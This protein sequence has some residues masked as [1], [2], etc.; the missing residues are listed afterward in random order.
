MKRKRG[1]TIVELMMVIAVIAI[2]AGII[3]MGV[4]G[5]FRSARAK[6]AEAMA[7][8]LQSGL[9]TYYAQYGKWPASIKSHENDDED[10]VELDN[11]SGKA[12]SAHGRSPETDSAFQ[13]IVKRSILSNGKPVLDPSGLFVAES[14]NEYC[15]DNHHHQ[16][17]SQAYGFCTRK[18][19]L[20]GRD[21][22]EAVKNT[23]DRAKISP[24]RM[25]FGYQGPN[26]GYFCRYRIIFHPKT[27]SV[28]VKMQPATIDFA[29]FKD[30]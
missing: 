24:D 22:T 21:F 3:T 8:V 11:S 4:S 2:L 6:R 28:E 13:E 1:F 25:V 9:E 16:E 27:D 15:C 29:G 26:N 20:R 10:S 23:K 5:M 30:D 12:A 7:R 14:A 17:K 18:S 19:C